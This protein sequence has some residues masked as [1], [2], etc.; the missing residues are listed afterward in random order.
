[1][2]VS[3]K[4]INKQP[5]STREDAQHHKSHSKR[6]KKRQTI[7]RPERQIKGNKRQPEEEKPTFNWGSRG[8]RNGQRDNTEKERNIYSLFKEKLETN[9]ANINSCYLCVIGSDRIRDVFF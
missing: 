5:T 6:G 7:K 4:K 3:P 8:R 2:D 9:R 1:M